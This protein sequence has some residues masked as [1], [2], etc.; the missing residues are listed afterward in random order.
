[1]LGKGT[2]QCQ[3]TLQ[4]SSRTFV[5][6][7]HATSVYTSRTAVIQ[8]RRSH[9]QSIVSVMSTVATAPTG[10]IQFFTAPTPNGHK[11]SVLLE[12]LKAT[13]GLQY[14]AKSLDFSKNE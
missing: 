8:N 13:Y 3:N 12:E 5:C 7:S 1:M 2:Y 4:I 6:R 14:T 9:P 10:T 11:V